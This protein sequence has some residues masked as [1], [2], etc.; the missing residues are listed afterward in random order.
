MRMYR[1]YC[2]FIYLKPQFLK[3]FTAD[4][5]SVIFVCLDVLKASASLMSIESELDKLVQKVRI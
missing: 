5:A 3:M 2:V 4:S 1:I